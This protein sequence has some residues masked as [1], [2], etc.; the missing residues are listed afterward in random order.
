MRKP[1]ANSRDRARSAAVATK[2]APKGRPKSN[3]VKTSN[4]KKRVALRRAIAKSAV[5][6]LRP[7]RGRGERKIAS[8]A[9]GTEVATSRGKYVYCIIEATEALKF[10]TIGIGADPSEVYTV[11]YKN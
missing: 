6:P 10:G 5:Q 2:A 7:A 1:P 3:A 8:A 11:H 9:A 4:R